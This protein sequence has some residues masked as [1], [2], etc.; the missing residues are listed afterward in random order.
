M[1]AN[2]ICFLKKYSDDSGVQFAVRFE[3]DKSEREILFEHCNIVDF[4]LEQLD[5]LIECL[6]RIKEEVSRI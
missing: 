6:Q 5:W 2:K 4:P 1:I 3:S